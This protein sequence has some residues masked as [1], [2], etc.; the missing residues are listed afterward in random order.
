ME[1][2]TKIGFNRD[3]DFDGPRAQAEVCKRECPTPVGD[4]AFRFIEHW[5]MVA[6]I[7][8]GEDS[9]G[10]AKLRLTTPEEVVDRAFVMAKMAAQRARDEGLMV[11]LPSYAELEAAE[12]K[13]RAEK[14]AKKAAKATA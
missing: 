5:G 6:A 14:E 10:R 8:D 2:E 9:Q 3:Y 4:L 1:I 13:R 11:P 7:H 12:Q